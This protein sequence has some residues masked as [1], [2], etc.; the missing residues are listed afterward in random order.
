MSRGTWERFT[1]FGS[2][3]IKR[4]Y[5]SKDG[6]HLFAFEFARRG[7]AIEVRCTHHPSLNG[8]DADPVKTH[9]FAS[10]RLCFVSGREP[11]TQ[12]RAEELAA[13]WGEYFLEYRRTGVA[14]S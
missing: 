7:V 12:R 5:R 6:N 14:Q 13:Q 3:V 9:L 2:N 4:T 1:L 8:Q 11:R 10:G